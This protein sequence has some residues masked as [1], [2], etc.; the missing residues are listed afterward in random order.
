MGWMMSRWVSTVAAAILGSVSNLIA[1]TLT[2][3]Y[4]HTLNKPANG[5]MQHK[6]TY[7]KSEAV[8]TLRYTLGYNKRLRRGKRPVLSGHSNRLDR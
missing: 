7:R 8:G 2:R 1:A 5:A 3:T 6:T 4:G